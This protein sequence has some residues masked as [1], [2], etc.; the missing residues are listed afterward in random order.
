MGKLVIAFVVLVIVSSVFG[1][2]SKDA[3]GA[4]PGPHP[5]NAI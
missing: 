2:N 3:A 5:Q 4:H 1:G